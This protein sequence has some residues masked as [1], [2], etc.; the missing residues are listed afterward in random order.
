MSRPPES[1]PDLRDARRKRLRYRAW[2][3][4]TKEM[5]LLLGRFAD[6]QLAGMTRA[7]LDAF[8]ALLSESDPDLYDW[9]SGRAPVPKEQINPMLSHLIAFSKPKTGA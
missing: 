4:G 3:R 9:I 2:H 5:D 1:A 7:Q 8:E 6:A